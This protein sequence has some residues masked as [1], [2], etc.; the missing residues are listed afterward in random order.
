MPTEEELRL[1]SEDLDECPEVWLEDM[2]DY[3]LDTH[4]RQQQVRIWFDQ[5]IV[6]SS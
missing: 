1:A 2:G 4:K 6:V 5:S 3:V